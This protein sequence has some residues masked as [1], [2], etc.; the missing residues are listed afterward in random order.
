LGMSKLFRGDWVSRLIQI[1]TGASAAIGGVWVV[2]DQLGL[3]HGDILTWHPEYFEISDGP[4][5][6]EFQVS[7]A[8]EK[9]RDDCTVEDFV[10]DVR[11]SKNIIHKATP[12]ISKFMGPA[13]H[14]IDT[15]AYRITIDNPGD[16]APGE[17]T[18]VAYIYY[19]CPEGKVIVN[20][21]DHP[22]T[23]F[24]IRED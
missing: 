18:L 3:L 8:R 2:I 17:A 16:V 7:V 10:V 15:F 14:R 20:Y 9:H 13:T 4:V 23:R 5:S 11:D 12:S 21:P 24:D 1:V 6:G 22:N 19:D